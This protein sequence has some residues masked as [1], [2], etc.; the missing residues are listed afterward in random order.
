M[1]TLR[2]PVNAGARLPA[3]EQV[4]STLSVALAEHGLSHLYLATNSID[5]A[6]LARLA[7]LVP[8]RRYSPHSAPDGE[9]ARRPEWLPAVELLLCANAAAFVGTL[10]STFSASALVQRDLLRRPR[11]STRFFGGVR[12]RNP[13]PPAVEGEAGGRAER[14]AR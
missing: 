8:Y 5:D 1:L 2:P 11:N 4:A 12:L 14:V 7:E 3:A 10:P 9:L 13:P 6:E